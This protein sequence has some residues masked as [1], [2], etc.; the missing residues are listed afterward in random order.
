MTISGNISSPEFRR[1]DDLTRPN[2]KYIMAN[3][4]CY[5]L[6][7]YA[8]G[9]GFNESEV[10][11]LIYNFKKPMDQK[12]MPG[13]H[14]KGNAIREI[15]NTFSRIF[16]KYNMSHYTIVPIPSSVAHGDTG[17]DDRI[18]KM[19]N[20]I[21]PLPNVRELICQRQSVIPSHKGGTR[22]P[23]EIAKNYKI[24]EPLVKPVP[25]MILVIDD[26]LTTGAHF[27]AVNTVLKRLYPQVRI[28]GL[29]IARRV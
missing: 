12:E 19:L 8:A 5:Y 17:H 27:R 13:W 2:H 4:R 10:N 20:L 3:D 7:E 18:I 29:F 26:I 21:R 28:S 11:Q 6:Y 1:I 14:Y 15:A 9:K 23:V 25:A 24:N 16:A 22:D